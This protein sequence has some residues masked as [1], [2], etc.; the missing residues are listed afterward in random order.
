[1][2]IE[3]YIPKKKCPYCRGKVEIISQLEFY[4]KEYKKDAKR[5][6]CVDCRASVGCHGTTTHAMGCLADNELKDLRQKIHDIVDKCWTT[7]K[8][9]VK[10]Y[11]NL[12]KRFSAC[13]DTFHIGWLKNEDAIYVLYDLEKFGIKS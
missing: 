12:A 2:K 11:A 10:I 3:H 4:G 7:K 1:M 9:R 6:H 13:G 5:Y 8:E